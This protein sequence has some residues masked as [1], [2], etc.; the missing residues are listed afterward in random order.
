M[1]NIHDLKIIGIDEMRPPRIRKEP[2]IDLFFEL[3]HQ[4]PAGW[5]SDFNSLMANNPSSPKINEK[6]GRF[7]EAWVRTPDEIVAFLEKLKAK[8][9]ECSREYIKRIELSIRSESNTDGSMAQ[10]SGE[11]GRLNRIIAALEFDDI[12]TK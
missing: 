2:Y 6:E 12:K 3:S 10:E 5:C 4:A 9:T 1:E 11:Q 7:I 8:V